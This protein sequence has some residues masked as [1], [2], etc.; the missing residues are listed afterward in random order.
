MKLYLSL[1]LL[2]QISH[3]ILKLGFFSLSLIYFNETNLSSSAATTYHYYNLNDTGSFYN[4]CKIEKL[5]LQGQK[6]S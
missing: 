3:T 1:L 5:E 4:T 6:Y 2:K